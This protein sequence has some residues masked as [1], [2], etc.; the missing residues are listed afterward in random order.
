MRILILNQYVPPDPAPTARCAGQLAAEWEKEG[1]EIVFVDGD[2]SYGGR[3]HRGFGRLF[4][5]MKSL[6]VM[7]WRA[8]RVPQADRIVSLSSPPMLGW[9]AGWI[10]RLRGLPH[11]HWIMDLYPDI[12]VSLGVMDDTFAARRFTAM[13]RRAYR[14]AAMIWVV[15][16][17]MQSRLRE[18]YGV[19]SA[20]RI[21]EPVRITDALPILAPA[22][23]WTWLYS[24][25]LGR[26]HEWKT[27]LEVQ[28]RLEEKGFPITLIFQGGGPSWKLAQEQ[29]GKMGLARCQWLPYAPKEE[30]VASLLR[31]RVLVAT[32]NPA[33]LG[34]LSPSKMNLLEKLPRP[35]LW[36]GPVE[37]ATV[38][39]LRSRGNAGWFKPG[40]TEGVERW[41]AACFEAPAAGH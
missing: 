23:E 19:E 14:R 24:G 16:A 34:Q 8:F 39:R 35:I 2:A 7:G 25:N 40:D 21:P 6:A 9:V 32:Q 3:A 17:D 1:H 26:A 31:S 33:T 15:D 30:L 37:S 27:L 38:E 36:V 5:E 22:E 12:A 18:K 41:L 13:M 20:V 4:R 28:R 11:Y 29:A 10:A